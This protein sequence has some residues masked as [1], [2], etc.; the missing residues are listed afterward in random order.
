MPIRKATLQETSEWLGNGLVMP[1]PKRPSSSDHSSTQQ[2][3][4]AP[5]DSPEQAA[6]AAYERAV[7]EKYGA[8]TDPL[9]TAQ[10]PSS[11][12]TTAQ[13]AAPASPGMPTGKA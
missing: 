12:S 11:A 9:A 10:A 3:K 8:G 7:S 1:G 5:Y 4:Q 13:P 6:A 2:P